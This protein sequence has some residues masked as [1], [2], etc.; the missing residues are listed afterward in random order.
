[1]SRIVR[2]VTFTLCLTA[3]LTASIAHA[4]FWDWD[5]ELQQRVWCGWNLSWATSIDPQHP[6]WLWLQ[7]NVAP[8]PRE[9]WCRYNTSPTTADCNTHRALTQSWADSFLGEHI[10]FADLGYVPECSSSCYP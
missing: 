7:Q 9:M 3:A 1:M 6:T 10:P 8:P 4:S 5:E 2:L